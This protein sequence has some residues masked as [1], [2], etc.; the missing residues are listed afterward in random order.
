MDVV[1]HKK[2]PKQTFKNIILKTVQKQTGGSRRFTSGRRKSI[3]G[4]PMIEGEKRGKTI[5]THRAPKRSRLD[6]FAKVKDDR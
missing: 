1:G 2:S 6:F 4:K 5:S 3:R